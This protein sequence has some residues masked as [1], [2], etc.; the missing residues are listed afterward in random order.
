MISRE[1]NSR[2]PKRVHET[3][4]QHR[5]HMNESAQIRELHRYVNDHSSAS[6]S[7]NRPIPKLLL[8]LAQLFSFS[9][10]RW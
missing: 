6:S 10:L 5:N 4:S 1:R 2:P 3:L 7:Q 8:R 9:N